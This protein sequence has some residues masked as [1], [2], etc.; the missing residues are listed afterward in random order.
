MW[1]KT[2]WSYSNVNRLLAKDCA[3]AEIRKPHLKTGR[4]ILSSL[5]ERKGTLSRPNMGVAMNVSQ[6]IH[7][8]A[9]SGA[10]TSAWLGCVI[11]AANASADQDSLATANSDF[12]FDLLKQIEGG[13][14][15]ANI[16]ISP[17]SVSTVLQMVSEGAAG[18]TQDELKQTLHL[19]E[20]RVTG[21]DCQSLDR[22]VTAGQDDV[23]LSLA[24]SIWYK[25]GFDLKPEYTAACTNYFQAATGALDFASPQAAAA[26]NDWAEKNTHGRIKDIVQ[27]PIDP[28]TRVILANAIYFKGRWAREFDQALTKNRAFTPPDGAA[29]PVPM[30]QQRGHFEY[31]QGPEYQAVRLSYAGQR[32]QMFLFLPAT[33]SS[34]QQ[35]LG[36]FAGDT[37]QNK[38]LP[39][40]QDHD[41]TVVLPR[42][43][44]N[45]DVR[46]NSPLQALGIKQAFS[47]NAD[48]SAMSDEKL[49]LSEVKQKSFVEVNEE[50]T[51]AAAVTTGTFHALAMMQPEK[52]F[53]MILDHPFFFVISEATTHSILFMGVVCDPGA[54]V[55]P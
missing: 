32:L 43:R 34:I 19:N 47:A 23:T 21:P 5:V 17:Y 22:A 27:S 42:F 54:A 45:F 41:G 53:E 10:L 31:Y 1:R 36:S 33:N 11:M 9:R 46:L 37:W 16:F 20:Q 52:P 29:K 51:E 28:L 12:A 7:K 8:I 26:I 49:Y 50:G 14:P 18:G 4:M 13:Q 24:N 48:F 2:K 30:M 39:Q 55:L 38:I 44:L 15:D 35:L 3:V 6:I 40:F 25:Q